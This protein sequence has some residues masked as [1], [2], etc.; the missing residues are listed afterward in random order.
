MM[1]SNLAT[2]A[3]MD[4]R[5]VLVVDADTRNPSQHKRFNT[6]SEPGLT[7]YLLG[8]EKLANVIHPTACKNVQVVP[9]GMNVPNPIQLLYSNRMAKFIDATRDLADLILFD[10]PACD[11]VIDPAIVASQVDGVLMV[12]GYETASKSKF[13]DAAELMEDANA[14]I[15]GVVS[16]DEN[17]TRT[18][19]RRKPLDLTANSGTSKELQATEPLKL[20]AEGSDE[21]V[22]ASKWRRPVGTVID[23]NADGKQESPVQPS[24]PDTA[25]PAPQPVKESNYVFSP[26]AD[27][28]GNGHKSSTNGNGASNKQGAE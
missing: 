24:T 2:V 16:M 17:A 8:R 22:V 26:T 20:T 18:I 21:A 23:T 1:I 25:A 14:K 15:I 12:T 4:G 5:R 11:G 13:I 9:C 27:S 10:V 6:P 3:G 19:R 7:D 28:N